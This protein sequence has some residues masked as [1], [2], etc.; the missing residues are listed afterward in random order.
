MTS[1]LT[2]SLLFKRLHHSPLSGQVLT[3]LQNLFDRTHLVH[4]DYIDSL[5]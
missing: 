4:L 1:E 5:L 3:K 2:L